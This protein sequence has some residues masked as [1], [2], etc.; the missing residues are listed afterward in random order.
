[1]TIHSFSL[2]G[3]VSYLLEIAN[4]FVP[5]QK[6]AVEW[7][8]DEPDVRVSFIKNSLVYYGRI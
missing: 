8:S 7:K 2:V 5:D 6:M 1:V 4:F 3:S